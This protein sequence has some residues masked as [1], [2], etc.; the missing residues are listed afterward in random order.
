[1]ANI[2]GR[3]SE[4]LRLLQAERWLTTAEA[5]FIRAKDELQKARQEHHICLQFTGGTRN[6][7]DL[8]TNRLAL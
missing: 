8:R 4:R 5:A 2:F 6:E 1:M 3:E 7:C